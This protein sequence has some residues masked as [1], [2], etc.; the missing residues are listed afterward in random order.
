MFVG[1]SEFSMIT[2]LHTKDDLSKHLKS[3]KNKGETIGFVPTMGALHAG[4][5]SL[6]EE[7]MS[8]TT[9]LV[10]SIFV[11]PTQFNNQND[12]EKYPRD[13]S[14]D[15]SIIQERLGSK[16]ICIYAPTVEDVYDD[17]VSAKKYTYDGLENVMEG[18]NRPGHFDGVGTILEFLFK[19]IKPDV[20]IF[21]EKDF[22]QLQIVKKLVKKLKLPIKIKGAAIHREPNM[23]AMSSRNERLSKAARMQAGFIYKS[24][25]LAKSHFKVHSV[26]QTE[27][28][29]EKLYAAQKDITLEYFTIADE[30]T[31]KTVTRKSKDRT[32]RA[33][34]VA[35]IEGV[36]LIDNIKLD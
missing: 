4:H 19:L 26:L 25:E 18:A 10:V 30:K 12:L 11:N 17:E 36:R 13:V 29:I 21:G 2:I 14:K 27:K 15:A 5:L 31:L 3:L 7:A 20:S 28:Y 33:F 8:L 35:H 24:L 22:Q 9:T 1:Y 23:L 34:I 32:C 16:N 6:M